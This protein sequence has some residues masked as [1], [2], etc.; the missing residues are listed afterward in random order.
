MLNELI[1]RLKQVSLY[2]GSFPSILFLV[3]YL[4]LIPSF[5]LIYYFLPNHFFHTTIQQ[6]VTFSDE[7]E[8][9]AKQLC[10]ELR[11]KKESRFVDQSTKTIWSLMPKDIRFN[12]LQAE[13]SG[14]LSVKAHTEMQQ[15]EGTNPLWKSSNNFSI[16]LYASPFKSI[17]TKDGKWID[18]RYIEIDGFESAPISEFDL[19]HVFSI[20]KKIEW[21]SPPNFMEF[22]VIDR[23]IGTSRDL[24]KKLFGFYAASKGFPSGT[25]G[26]FWRMLYLS[27]VVITTLGFG[28]IVPITNT[29]RILVVIE[30]IIG[31]I[32]I[33]LFLNSLSST[34]EDENK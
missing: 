25:K 11:P 19:I 33:G 3:I 12:S 31:I 34:N 4:L 8:Q 30:A 18:L 26:N 17:Q 20:W 29:A 6:E 32:L 14:K 21:L 27:T 10:D 1:S 9:L 22:M 28:D 5:A 7:K 23:V 24:S 15:Y 16:L 13:E 2:L